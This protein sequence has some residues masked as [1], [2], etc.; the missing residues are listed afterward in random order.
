MKQLGKY[1]GQNERKKRPH[2]L[3]K[4]RLNQPLKLPLLPCKAIIKHRLFVYGKG[5]NLLSQ[6]VIDERSKDAG[7]YSIKRI[8]K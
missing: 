3:Q 5:T 2:L 7:G 6:R 8:L 4:L 1:G